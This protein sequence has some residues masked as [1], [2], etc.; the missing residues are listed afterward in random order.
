MQRNVARC[1]E[2][3]M[4]RVELARRVAS[5]KQLCRNLACFLRLLT[6][7]TLGHVGVG[8][9]L[10]VILTAKQV[11]DRL[12]DRLANDV[13]QRHFNRR[14]HRTG[15]QARMSEIMAG[16]IHRLPNML[17]LE[18]IPPDNEVVH[19]LVDDRDERL[20]VLQAVREDI[21]RDAFA[22]SYD[23][24]IGVQFQK[25]QI[26]SAS[27]RR[28]VLYNHRLVVSNLHWSVRW[29]IVDWRQSDGTAF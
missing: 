11:V 21:A 26:P 20:E 18:R 24:A 5:L 25:Q 9:Q 13:P 19:I 2:E 6:E 4:E 29:C 3:R 17:N 23:P 12:I 10:V 14:Q 28:V 22:Q 1:W 15:V 27:I 7:S 16:R 8:T